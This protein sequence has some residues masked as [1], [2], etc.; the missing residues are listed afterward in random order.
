MGYSIGDHLPTNSITSSG[1]ITDSFVEFHIPKSNDFIDLSQLFLYAN[2]S[3]V[4]EGGEKCAADDH[5]CPVNN[6]LHSLFASVELYLNQTLIVERSDYFGVV[7]YLQ[8]ILGLDSDIKQTLGSTM[9]YDDVL[10]LKDAEITSLAGHQPTREWKNRFSSSKTVE[11]MG[12]L[13]VDVSSLDSLLISGVEVH[14]RLHR[15]SNPY[16]INAPT[17]RYQ[18]QLHQCKL[19]SK[20]VVP[21]ASAALALEQAIQRSPLEMMFR[22]H[23]VKTYNIQSGERTKSIENPFLGYAPS[24]LL[25]S[26]VSQKA[27]YG[28]FTR[29]PH[30]L[31][32]MGLT[33]LS[34]TMDGNSVA[35]YVMNYAKD[36]YVQPYFFSLLNWGLEQ[37]NHGLSYTDFKESKNVYIFDLS[38]EDSAGSSSLLSP[39]GGQV[40]SLDRKGILRMNF[41]FENTVEE[42]ASIV[43][44]AVSQASLTIT[45]DRR[46]LPNYIM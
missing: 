44:V 22:R 14:I 17:G 21:T 12:Q 20:K 1:E 34:M 3:V 31:K 39:Q 4:K 18:M 43:L 36:H 8:T 33:R 24:L 38:P 19:F 27:L 42:N 29:D 11:L 37:S 10:T 25:V 46:V 15:Q 32:N 13:M 40:L 5:Y 16:L 23:T 7:S 41:A 35:E 45:S 28:D 2:V 6:L 9:G 30:C 26:I